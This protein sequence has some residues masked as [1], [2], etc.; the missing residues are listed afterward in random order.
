MFKPFIQG[1]EASGYWLEFGNESPI[2]GHG[3]EGEF[4]AVFSNPEE[5]FNEAV[6]AF[7]GQWIEERE[8]QITLGGDLRL[9]RLDADLSVKVVYRQVNETVISKSIEIHADRE[10]KFSFVNRLK[11]VAVPEQ[12]W[13]FE[14]AEPEGGAVYELLPAAGMVLGGK[15]YGLLTDNGYRNRWT[16]I[17]RRKDDEGFMV[18][19]DVQPDPELL[20][21]ASDAER[22]AGEHYVQYKFGEALDFTSNT[23][24]PVALPEQSTWRSIKS[25]SHHFNDAGSLIVSGSTEEQSGIE[26][27]IELDKNEMYEIELVYRSPHKLALSLLD[28][29]S[30]SYFE[31]GYEYGAFRD[32][33]PPTR[34]GEY[35]SFSR[36]FFSSRFQRK[37]QPLHLRIRNDVN[38]EGQ[39]LDFEIKALHI[40]KYEG[41]ARQYHTAG[42]SAPAKLRLILF[43]SEASSHRE[44]QIAS[45]VKLAEGLGMNGTEAEKI[46]Y[47]NNQMLTWIV[48]HDKFEPHLVP[49]L[50]YHPDMYLRDAFWHA[51][52]TDDKEV[53][54]QC[55]LRYAETQH[56]DG[57]LDT[58]VMPYY[59][60]SSRDDNDSTLFFLMWA[61]INQRKYGT[62]V[63]RKI[64]EKTFRSIINNHSPERDGLY[65]SRTAGW[66]DTIWS[67]DKIRSINQGH[68]AVAL[69]CAKELGLEVLQ[70]EIEKAKNA[71]RALYDH[72][73]QTLKWSEDEDYI[74]PSVLLGEFLNLWLYNEPILSS[75]QVINTVERFPVIIRGVPCICDADGNFFTDENKPWEGKYNWRDGVYHNG[76]SWFLY[77]YLA[78][79]AAAR[80]GWE[81]GKEKMDWRVKMEFS[82]ENE[83]YSHE[84]I[85]LSHDDDDWWPSVGVFAWNTFMIAANRVAE[86]VNLF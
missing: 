48:Q 38:E 85:P 16:R 41:K 36:R 71:Y 13:T 50:N 4:H 65:W 74:S 58:L 43:E 83:P 62:R 22:A 1:N 40:R 21:I 63:D 79:A 44:V 80:H 28:A 57:Q 12:Y 20:A 67:V 73:R 51:A 8:G 23:S 77:E 78:Y 54:E 45:Q 26:I 2:L 19:L 46:M 47:A 14:N 29:E 39:P 64:L 56:E 31:W 7:R 17:I 30:S 11:A 52:A 42:P 49:S 69:Q 66:L 15:A 25:A 24:S 75:E 68:Y 27:P 61:C 70:D 86:G 35:R 34:E 53:S 6:H 18:G 72:E 60:R 84:F 82:R 37:R 10:L 55:W 81:Q 32:N 3:D 33:I 5:T 76:G 59:Y 9:S